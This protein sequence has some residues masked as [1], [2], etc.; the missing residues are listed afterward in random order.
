MDGGFVLAGG[1]E[2][3]ATFGFGDG[4]E[5]VLLVNV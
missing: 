2:V 4:A 1:P 3:E 5:V